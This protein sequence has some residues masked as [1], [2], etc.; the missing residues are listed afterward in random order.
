MGTSTGSKG[1]SRCSR[2]GGAATIVALVLGLDAGCGGG[3]ASKAVDGQHASDKVSATRSSSVIAR[4]EAICAREI[5]AFKADAPKDATTAE[6]IR[7]TPRRVAEETRVVSEL[8][9]LAIPAASASGWR[10]VLAA[11]RALARELAELG[12]AAR[13]DDRAAI[14]RLEKSKASEHQVLLAAAR[15]V[16][17][18]QCGQTQ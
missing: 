15:R 18:E 9:G 2:V 16:G 6:L 4:A 12:A 5:A 17:L 10:E 3:A 11:R 13:R 1:P 8:S 7:H 14:A